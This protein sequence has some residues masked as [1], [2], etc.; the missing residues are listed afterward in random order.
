LAA[1]RRILTHFF[2]GGGIGWFCRDGVTSFGS[3]VGLRAMFEAGRQKS[4]GQRLFVMA[5]VIDVIPWFASL[6]HQQSIL[7]L[8]MPLHIESF[9]DQII[10]KWFLFL[11]NDIVT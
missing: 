8:W 5:N 6:L 9:S 3:W 11:Q 1:A 7:K 2:D 4:H 10:H